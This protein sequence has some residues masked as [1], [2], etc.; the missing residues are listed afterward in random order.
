MGPTGVPGDDQSMAA[1]ELRPLQVQRQPTPVTMERYLLIL[2]AMKCGT[3]A[4][5]QALSQHPEILPCVEK[6]PAFW[7]RD[8]ARD[9]GLEGY[10]QLWQRHNPQNP[11]WRLEASTGYSKVPVRPSPAPVLSWQPAEFRFLYVTRN[12]LQR[13]RSQYEMSL[14]RGWFKEPITDGLH[15]STLWFSKHHLQLQPYVD[16]FGKESIHVLSYE[17]LCANPGRT[18]G[19]IAN[20]LG[21]DESPLPSALPRANTS[22]LFRRQ[23]TRS[24]K[25]GQTGEELQ[26]ALDAEVTPSP[27][28]AQYIREVL[29]DDAASMRRDWGLDVWTG[30]RTLNQDVEDAP[31]LVARPERVIGVH[32]N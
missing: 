18:L 12:P 10:R 11:G 3:T 27:A 2:G 16:W 19:G 29:A 30:Q 28:Q 13:I 1:L 23:R 17:E 7:L 9:L 6:E 20:F 15:P 32:H 26:K 21:V 22:G 4:L 5:F 14:S 24:A 8:D 25:P 31:D